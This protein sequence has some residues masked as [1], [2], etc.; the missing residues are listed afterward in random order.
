[1]VGRGLAVSLD[2]FRVEQDEGS[3]SSS[4]WTGVLDAHTA[5]CSFRI[6]YESRHPKGSS[7]GPAVHR[8]PLFSFLVNRSTPALGPALEGKSDDWW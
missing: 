7:G 6:V 8:M 4:Y 5:K 2:V 1:M 3:S